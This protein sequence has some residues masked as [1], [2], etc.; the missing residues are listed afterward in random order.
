MSAPNQNAPIS[1]STPAII[2]TGAQV[3]RFHAQT[4]PIVK[5]ITFSS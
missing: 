1:V 2:D 3:V 4:A 5:V